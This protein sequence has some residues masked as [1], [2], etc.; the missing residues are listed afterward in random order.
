M[1]FWS[2]FFY[3]LKINLIVLKVNNA[4][5]LEKGG[6]RETIDGYEAHFGTNYL[7]R[8]LHPLKGLFKRNIK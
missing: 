3:D 4:G 5:I 1:I 7:G 8:I 6:R 2:F